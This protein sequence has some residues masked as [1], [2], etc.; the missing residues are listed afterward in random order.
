MFANQREPVHTVM[1]TKTIPYSLFAMRL[2]HFIWKTFTAVQKVKTSQ[3]KQNFRENNENNSHIL[4]IC[5]V[6]SANYIITKCSTESCTL[7]LHILFQC[8]Q[9]NVGGNTEHVGSTSRYL[10]HKPPPFPPSPKMSPPPPHEAFCVCHNAA[11]GISKK[12][13][14]GICFPLQLDTKWDN[15]WAPTNARVTWESTDESHT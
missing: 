9:K 1:P 11:S 6:I 2:I 7:W 4:W 15:I 12:M 3:E 5:K 8:W 13:S 10:T 14:V